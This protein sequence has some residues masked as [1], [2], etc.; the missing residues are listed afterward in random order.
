MN[1]LSLLILLSIFLFSL[2]GLAQKEIYPDEFAKHIDIYKEGQEKGAKGDFAEAISLFNAAA[3][4]PYLANSS[5]RHLLSVIAEDANRKQISPRLAR[6]IFWIKLTIVAKKGLEE[7]LPSYGN[8]ILGNPNYMPLYLF[9]GKVQEA[10]SN[11]SLAMADFDK[12]VELSPDSF[13]PYFYRGHCLIFTRELDRALAD[14]NRAIELAPDFSPS[15]TESI[16]ALV[17]Q[18]NYQKALE[19]HEEVAKTDSNYQYS[20]HVLDAYEMR[21][22]ARRKEKK[23]EEALADFNA[24]ISLND[25]SYRA[26]WNRGRIYKDMKSYQAAIEDYSLA[27]TK[28]ILSADSVQIFY[29]RGQAYYDMD[30]PLEAIKDYTRAIAL[31]PDFGKAYY[32]RAE[33]YRKNRDFEI[34]IVNFDKALSLDPKNFWIYYQKAHTFEEM[35]NFHNAIESYSKFIQNAPDKYFKHKTHAEKRIKQLT[36]TQ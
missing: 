15:F 19:I 31:K 24:I 5:E 10:L 21:G 16:R 23:F 29:Q 20:S 30:Q 2:Y 17:L 28:A 25:K 18:D 12:A 34:S 22:I 35:G 8:L 32:Q 14:L 4:H 7:A 11:Y 3:H 36:Q 6:T 33:A 1:R 13:L 26:Y 9:R 27:I